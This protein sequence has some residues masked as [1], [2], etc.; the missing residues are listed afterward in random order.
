MTPPESSWGPGAS[1]S[2][3]KSSAANSPHASSTKSAKKPVAKKPVAKNPA[4]KAK[5]A[6]GD[7]APRDADFTASG[8]ESRTDGERITVHDG[9][10]TIEAG[11]PRERAEAS[12]DG[13]AA[14]A[15]DVTTTREP[16]G[17]AAT[18][19]PS[20]TA[21]PVD[22]APIAVVQ[23]PAI[24]KPPYVPRTATPTAVAAPPP[25]KVDVPAV[26]TPVERVP[27]ATPAPF[28]RRLSAAERLAGS[29]TR[30]RTR[31]RE[32]MTDRKA[33]VISL[34]P[35]VGIVG[36]LT[37]AA[38]YTAVSPPQATAA[39]P[40]LSDT[41]T[42]AQAWL[43]DN[44]V[45]GRPII[46]DA[47]LVPGLVDAGWAPGDVL[48]AGDA[49][50]TEWREIAYVASAGDGGDAATDAAI[51]SS[52]PAATFGD[53]EIRRVVPEGAVIAAASERSAA[54]TRREFGAEIS[55]NPGVELSTPDRVTLASGLVDERISAVLGA[56]AAVGVVTVTDLPVIAG[57]EGRTLR[58]VSLS[59]VGDV[60]LV[61]GAEPSEQARAIFDALS[62]DYALDA[63]SVDG[64]DLVLRFPL[65]S[66]TSPE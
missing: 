51:R 27:E 21:A 62:G 3:A 17:V 14:P 55:R 23:R 5:N 32:W 63:L 36:L 39:A 41:Q 65:P 66:E 48:T 57:E 15:E 54:A 37:G 52:V 45:P 7:R 30:V 56:L 8:A 59:G 4:A 16:Q 35:V 40:A 42:A 33:I 11:T 28:P 53:L 49:S 44:A 22:T 47:A 10:M 12:A 31:V 60:P 34:V 38:V 20:R 24:T 64:A 50:T 2:P 6:T 46:V 26:V 58:Q 19:P 13:D 43:I 25:Q 9:H 1:T 29:T 18:E 61:S